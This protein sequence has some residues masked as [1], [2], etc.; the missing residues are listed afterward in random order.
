MKP[1][2]KIISLLLLPMAFLSCKDKIEETY[3][4]NEPVY[5][6][7]GDLRNSF[8]VAAGQDIVQ[9]GKIY[10]K[11]NY[12]FV[13]E[14]QKGIH[15]VD[16]TD[17]ESPQVIKFIEIPG[18]VDLAVK[19]DILYA[20]SF[21]D[22]LA[23]DI[24]DVNNIREVKR[25]QN[26]FQ[27]MIP[28]CEDGIVENVDQNRGVIV[29]YTATEKTVSVDNI[30]ERYNQLPVWR[31][32]L[33]FLADYN[34]VS[35][36]KTNGGTGTGGSLARFTVYDN[37]LYTV[38]N[39]SLRLFDVS[40]SE[41]PVM[42][43]EM[44]VGWNI[45]TIFPYEQKLFLG[46]TTGLYVYSL[47][48]PANPSFVSQFRHASSCDPVVVQGDYAYVTLRAGNLCGDIQSQL[49]VIDISDIQSP[50]L[51][52]EYAM[53]E[54]YGLGI[55]GELLFVCDGNAGLKIFNANDPM[56]IDQNKIA[57]YG[58]INAY[59]VI[60]LG[61]VLILIGTNGLYQYDYSDPE[62]IRV[63]S[64]IPIVDLQHVF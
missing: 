63:L 5:M 9:P 19:E 14:Y 22:L 49:D 11:G 59:D 37:F 26:V 46:S 21:I 55:D 6:T 39:Y 43:S 53:E 62:N 42:K 3:T 20:D 7:Y 30:H 51:V 35:G 27:Y 60:P 36:G 56:A 12:I 1:Y 47:A 32:E 24:S 50:S 48:D 52:K 8:K 16:N 44:Y 40:T 29:G 2:L 13:N 33:V 34:S 61:N 23:I 45:E 41:D 28:A 31:G 64:V 57:E 38:D 15:I 25:I 54:P 10:F 17:P 4:V 18:N 58:D